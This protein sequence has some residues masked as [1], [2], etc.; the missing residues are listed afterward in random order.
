MGLLT[1]GLAESIIGLHREIREIWE[2]I[3]TP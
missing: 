3:L 2:K 1:P